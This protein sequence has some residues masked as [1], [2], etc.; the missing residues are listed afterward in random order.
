MPSCGCRLQ[1]NHIR[2]ERAGLQEP[3]VP[4]VGDIVL[5][6]VTRINKRMCTAEIVQ[7]GE[8]QL[9]VPFQGVIRV[10]DVRATEIDKVCIFGGLI[11]TSVPLESNQKET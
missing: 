6:R 1:D 9:P 3:R 10:Q 7:I 5:S 11:T 8:Q 2:V 4:A